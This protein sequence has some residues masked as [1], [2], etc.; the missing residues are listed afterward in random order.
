MNKKE[1]IKYLN[2]AHHP[3]ENGYFRRSYQAMNTINTKQGCRRLA[4]AI[5][6]LL[7]DD[8]PHGYLHRNQ[9]DI[10]HCHHVGSAIQY[11]V[12]SENGILRTHLLGSNF[13]S[14]EYPQLIVRGGEWK[15]SQLSGGEFG[16]ISEVVAPGFEY[17]D[18]EVATYKQANKLFPELI[19]R[20]AKYIKK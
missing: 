6:Y 1:I 5:Y 7:T 17:E 15:I 3:T 20:L 19:D 12:I 9:S 14:G 16:L 13:Y 4:T 8:Q 18:N 10:I 11:Y 2:L